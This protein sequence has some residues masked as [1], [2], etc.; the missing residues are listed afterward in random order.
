MSSTTYRCNA[1]EYGTCYYCTPD[2]SS[3]DNYGASLGDN[4]PM[5]CP[6]CSEAEASPE[7]IMTV[8]PAQRGGYRWLVEGL[9]EWVDNHYDNCPQF[10]IDA[11][12]GQLIQPC[13]ADYLKQI[14]L[15]RM[16]ADRAEKTIYDYDE[17]DR[18][19]RVIDKAKKIDLI[20]D[21][22]PAAFAAGV[23]YAYIRLQ[24]HDLDGMEEVT[25][26]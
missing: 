26:F 22:I 7:W 12:Y 8:S 21:I 18:I 10:V 6:L 5:Y 16:L 14:D 15:L 11:A 13:R 19:K 17:R 20:N 9:L 24:T 1:C 25:E 3:T 4:L 23:I 2:T